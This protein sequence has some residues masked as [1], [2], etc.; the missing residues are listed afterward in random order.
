M[1]RLRRSRLSTRLQEPYLSKVDI[2]T[3]ACVARDAAGSKN[4]RQQH[5]RLAKASTTGIPGT[6]IQDDDRNH[7]LDGPHH[8]KK[9]CLASE[10]QLCTA[11]NGLT[12]R[13]LPIRHCQR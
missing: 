1:A 12:L 4:H 3:L 9:S 6:S 11:N 2:D 10:Q 8:T 5:H 13:C 7:M